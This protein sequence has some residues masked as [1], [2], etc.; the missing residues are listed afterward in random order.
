MKFLITDILKA[1][2]NTCTETGN[3]LLSICFFELSTPDALP[4]YTFTIT[5]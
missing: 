5:L 1:I 4:I 3:I 2:Q